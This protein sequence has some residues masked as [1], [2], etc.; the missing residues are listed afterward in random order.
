MDRGTKVRTALAIIASVNIALIT[1]EADF[2]QFNNPAV[3]LVYKIISLA[4][5]FVV[6]AAAAYY[7][8]NYTEAGQIGTAITRAM[9]EDPTKIAAI[10]IEDGDEDDEDDPEEDADDDGEEVIEENEM[11]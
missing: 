11:E 3:E 6:V 2:L 5:N 8:N 9:K 7:N 10:E 1:L 4:A